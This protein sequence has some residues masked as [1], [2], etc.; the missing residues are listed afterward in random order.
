MI[1]NVVGKSK[2]DFSNASGEII[3]GTTLYVT[4]IVDNVEGL[5][6]EKFFIKESISCND[7]NVGDNIE[8]FFNQRGKVDTIRKSK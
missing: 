1:V 6:A 3:R 5:K 7:V 8:I 4:H 2:V